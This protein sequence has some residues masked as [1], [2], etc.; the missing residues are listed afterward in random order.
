MTPIK[1]VTLI[2]GKD[3]CTRPYWSSGSWG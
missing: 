3:L 2:R 1:G